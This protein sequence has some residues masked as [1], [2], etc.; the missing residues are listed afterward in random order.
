MGA[1]ADEQDWARHHGVAIHH[2]ATPRR[3]LSDGKV[4]TGVEFVQTRLEAGRLVE[5]GET[6]TLGADM[7]LKA[8]GQSLDGVSALGG[9]V[10]EAGRI[11]TTADGRTSRPKVW[12]GGDCRHGGRDLTVEGVEHG[13][14]A[15]LSIDAELRAT[16]S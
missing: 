13:K 14:L 3:V 7:L 12:A 9:V 11:K 6:F 10:L 8:I 4:V 15:A 2:W 5:T 16:R 1:S